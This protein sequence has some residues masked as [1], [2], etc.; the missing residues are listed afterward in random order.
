VNDSDDT[1]AGPEAEPIWI[2]ARCR[3]KEFRQP[4]IC[5]DIE[6]QP[7]FCSFRH[8]KNRSRFS[9]TGTRAAVS[10]SAEASLT[11]CTAGKTTRE[12]IGMSTELK[13][14]EGRYYLH[15]DLARFGF[16][17]LLSAYGLPVTLYVDNGASD[18]AT[19]FHAA[20]DALDIQLVHSKP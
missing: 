6:A 20:C 19:R 2:D 7:R 11:A 9:G 12:K 13:A 18:Q 14:P 1:V 3:F 5:Q 10:S 15:E 8:I 16:Q 4:E 17:R